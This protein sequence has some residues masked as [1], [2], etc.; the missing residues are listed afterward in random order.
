[1]NVKVASSKWH[2]KSDIH[3]IAG[4]WKVKITGEPGN[5]LSE[6]AFTVTLPTTK[7]VPVSGKTPAVNSEKD[8]K[9]IK[10]ALKMLEPEKA[11]AN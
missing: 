4:E 6:K 10:D 5:I 7:E 3:A 1:M 2:G 8:T 9:K 11:K